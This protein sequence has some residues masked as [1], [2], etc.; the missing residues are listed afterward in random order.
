A[1]SGKLD[2]EAMAQD[3]NPVESAVSRALRENLERIQKTTD[4]LH[5]AVND[6][7]AACSSNKAT[8]ALPP[9]V[10]AQTAAASL[11]AALDVLTRFVAISLQQG[12]RSALETQIATLVSTAAVP[13][14]PE[15]QRPQPAQP[16]P[17]ASAPSPAP[18]TRPAPPPP[19]VPVETELE[20]H[21]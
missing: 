8:H 4:D 6:L 18:T 15:P 3:T 2:L 21:S 10:R 16:V 5:H 19:H 20:L 12:P 13:A 1:N 11:S 14:P 7:V 9:L 17:M